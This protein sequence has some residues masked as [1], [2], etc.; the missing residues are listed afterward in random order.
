MNQEDVVLLHKKVRLALWNRFKT[1]A[2]ERQRFEPEIT[3]IQIR[4]EV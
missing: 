2:R 1:H 3:I 4:K